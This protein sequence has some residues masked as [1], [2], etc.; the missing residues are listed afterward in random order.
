MALVGAVAA[1][2]RQ[3][4]YELQ[5]VADVR[6]ERL[7]IDVGD[8]EGLAALA[9]WETQLIWR[10]TSC[11]LDRLVLIWDS[12]PLPTARQDLLWHISLTSSDLMRR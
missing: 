3:A 9:S 4:I 10:T 6:P 1:P 7:R 8:L 12:T 5:P 11:L 2:R